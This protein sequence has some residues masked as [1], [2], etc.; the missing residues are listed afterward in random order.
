MNVTNGNFTSDPTAV[1]IPTDWHI[2][3]QHPDWLV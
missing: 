2:Q 3:P 1:G